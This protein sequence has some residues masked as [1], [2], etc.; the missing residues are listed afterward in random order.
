M[1]PAPLAWINRHL[2]PGVMGSGQGLRR[3]LMLSVCSSSLTEFGYR[4][5]F[6]WKR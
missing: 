2:P 6:F 1:A 4:L 3:K 5:N